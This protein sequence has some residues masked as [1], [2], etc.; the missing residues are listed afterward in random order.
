MNACDRIILIIHNKHLDSSLIQNKS[1][2][3]IVL[4]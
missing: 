4:N 3:I 1:K 2:K